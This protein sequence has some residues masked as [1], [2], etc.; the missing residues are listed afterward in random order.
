MRRKAQNSPPPLA[1]HLL[2]LCNS[3]YKPRGGF[4]V[5]FASLIP[6]IPLVPSSLAKACTEG[7]KQGADAGGCHPGMV[8]EVA[9]VPATGVGQ[10]PPLLPTA[11]LGWGV[12]FWSF[13]ITPEQFWL[14]L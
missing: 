1:A 2:L 3:R 14:C 6:C 12:I 11:G 4:K 10:L 9:A 5:G 13:L 7:G 8:A